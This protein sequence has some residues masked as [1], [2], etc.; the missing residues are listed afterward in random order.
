[1]ISLE[2]LDLKDA[3]VFVSIEEKKAD[4]ATV[5]SLLGMAN[6]AQYR[7]DGNYQKYNSRKKVNERVKDAYDKTVTC[8]LPSNAFIGNPLLESLQLP[9]TLSNINMAGIGGSDGYSLSK[10]KR[11]KEIW[12]S[13]VSAEK[14]PIKRIVNESKVQINYY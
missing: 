11:L 10:K 2:K 12:M 9:A 8:E 13:N 1:M 4:A 14:I 6:E 3:I 5:A 7:K